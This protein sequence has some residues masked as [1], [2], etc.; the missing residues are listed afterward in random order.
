MAKKVKKDAY[1]KSILTDDLEHCI[2]CGRDP[3]Q[4]HHIFGGPD[5]DKAT[6]DDM[7]IPLCWDCHRKL[8]VE[9][10][11]Q[12]RY[13]FMREAQDRWELAYIESHS[14]GSIQS[15]VDASHN[16]RDEFRKRYGKSYL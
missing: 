13:R 15:Y 9:P 3:V 2:L 10:S 5:R 1:Q 12:T 16:A 14:N 6:N 4:F 7:I 8:H 11:Q